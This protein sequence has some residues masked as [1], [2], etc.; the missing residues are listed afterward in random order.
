[1]KRQ[2]RNLAMTLVVALSFGSLGATA[3]FGQSVHSRCR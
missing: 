1:M 3:A 2:T